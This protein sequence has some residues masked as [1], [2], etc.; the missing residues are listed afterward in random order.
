[1]KDPLRLL[2][3][4]HSVIGNWSK[5]TNQENSPHTRLPEEILC[6]QPRKWRMLFFNMFQWKIHGVGSKI[7]TPCLEIGQKQKSPKNRPHTGLP[8]EIL[9][10]QQR[11]LRRLLTL[12]EKLQ[13]KIQSVWSKACT[14]LF[15]NWPKKILY[16]KSNPEHTVGQLQGNRQHQRDP[17][18]S[19]TEII[20]RLDDFISKNVFNHWLWWSYQN[21]Y[22]QLFPVELFH[23]A[24]KVF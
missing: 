6:N 3:Y 23:V 10:N 8:D 14:P 20:K 2:K 17:R 15:R 24:Q 9:C 13:L 19:M 1:M 22:L 5:Q 4:F 21:N 11:N 12:F 16:C 18:Q 7:F